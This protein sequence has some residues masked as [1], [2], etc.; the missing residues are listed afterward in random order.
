MKT[1]HGAIS[2]DDAK[3]PLVLVEYEGTITELDF[4]SA[5]Q[6]YAELAHEHRRLVWL[7][8]MQR[9]E[10][11]RVDAVVRKGAAAIF[12]EHSV[13]LIRSTVAEA[14]VMEGFIT[15]NVV[16]AF[17]WLTS[18]NKWPCRQFAKLGAAEAWLWDAYEND[19][20]KS[21]TSSGSTKN[22]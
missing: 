1:Q 16:V 13:P 22:H 21:L 7:V 6:R 9:F 8:D 12:E 14:R 5:F 2:I 17:D 10:P 3:V 19:M 18:A 20:K 15:R 11:L 4:R